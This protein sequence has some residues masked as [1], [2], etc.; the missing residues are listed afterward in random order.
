MLGKSFVV[1]GKLVVVVGFDLSLL[2]ESYEN[3]NSY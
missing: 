2:K 1:L 3:L